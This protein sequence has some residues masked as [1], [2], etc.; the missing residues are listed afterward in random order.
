MIRKSLDNNRQTYKPA[1]TSINSI[2]D[3]KTLLKCWYFF[4]S[5]V[6]ICHRTWPIQVWLQVT[7][8]TRLK[9]QLLKQL[10]KLLQIR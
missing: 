5:T 1:T 3:K 6:P 4:N 2:I 10:H 9:Q 8:I 7:E